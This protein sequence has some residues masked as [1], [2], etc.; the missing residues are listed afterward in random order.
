MPRSLNVRKP[1]TVEIRQQHRLLEGEL[2]AWQRRRVETLLLYTAGH[3]AR[4]IASF[5]DVH[6]HTVYADLRPF[7]QEGLASAQQSR[8]MG[9]PSRL[10]ADQRAEIAASQCAAL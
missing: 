4:D 1:E 5:L 9:A 10:T 7:E 2:L 3:N 8:R 6:V